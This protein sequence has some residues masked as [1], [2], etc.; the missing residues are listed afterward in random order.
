MHHKQHQ[1]NVQNIQKP[2]FF[3]QVYDPNQQFQRSN[4]NQ[5]LMSECKK[6]RKSGLTLL[7]GVHTNS[8]SRSKLHQ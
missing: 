4:E 8:T 3:A 6:V 1:P 7:K 2:N 5:S